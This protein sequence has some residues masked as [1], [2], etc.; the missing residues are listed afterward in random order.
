M[1]WEILV[2]D[3]L[4]GSSTSHHVGSLVLNK[5]YKINNVNKIIQLLWVLEVY[6]PLAL[7]SG[8]AA[9]WLYVACLLPLS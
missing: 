1:S 8:A 7:G 2:I 3:V 4:G 5:D 9:A 6:R